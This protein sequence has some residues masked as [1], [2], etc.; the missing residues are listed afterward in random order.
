MEAS[1]WMEAVSRARAELG[2]EAAVPRG[3]TCRV[4]PGG[5][6]TLIDPVAQRRYV[7]GR[8]ERSFVP[9]K[10]GAPKVPREPKGSVPKI[11][12]P[13]P[14][15]LGR[16]PR[17]ARHA[18]K[19][20]VPTRT[21]AFE[22]PPGPKSE[23]SEPAPE[24]K[25]A[26]KAVPT[27]TVAFEA[28]PGPK[29]DAPPPSSPPRGAPMPEPARPPRREVE[30]G[31]SAPSPADS[32]KPSS[33]RGWKLLSRRDHDPSEDNPLRYRERIYVVPE[34]TE[35]AAVERFLRE[36]FDE[37]RSSL[38][39][40]APGRFV[41]LVA[42]DHAWSERPERPPLLILQWKDWR[43]EPV[44]QKPLRSSTPLAPTPPARGAGSPP[45]ER[46]SNAPA[47][48]TPSSPPR[49]PSATPEAEATNAL[50][51]A[52]E[53]CQDLLF[54]QTPNEGMHFVVRLLS[55]LIPSKH[56]AG[57]LYDINDDV[58]RL[59]AFRG[60]GAE[61]ARRGHTVPARQGLF[62]AAATM[63]GQVLRVD[64]L[65]SDTRF[66]PDAEVPE[67]L[68]PRS[69]LYMALECRGVLLGA[70]QVL[71]RTDAQHFDEDDVAVLQYVGRQLAEFLSSARVQ[72]GRASE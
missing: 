36:R 64:D 60:H 3:A 28:P 58:W 19:K 62:G 45:R 14:A 35:E 40:G 55:E 68:S 17:S 22:A 16:G 31:S 13:S 70:I 59:V 24:P 65:A 39:H 5:D 18:P 41:N 51:T 57:A 38:E 48:P 7:V 32:S 46:A 72:A 67:G 29:P 2:E 1:N 53:A 10:A 61:A 47:R 42:F 21:V 50:A 43:G 71:E 69:A 30:P 34:G 26:P 56:V 23:P 25:A 27:R 8:L 49:D 15:D 66:D 52:F 33:L 37:V 54:L 12:L 63:P 6:V 11:H 4:A 9:R 20:A 44:L